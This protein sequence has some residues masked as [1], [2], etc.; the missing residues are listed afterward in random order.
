M[1]QAAEGQT[2]NTRGPAGTLPLN[3]FETETSFNP[4][5][6]QDLRPSD[7]CEYSEEGEDSEEDTPH[8]V[9]KFSTDNDDDD[10]DSEGDVDNEET[11]QKPFTRQKAIAA[12][13]FSDGH[14]G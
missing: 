13:C 2:G 14:L 1:C 7:C 10:S 9:N 3:F 6:F 4:I 8:D 11:V 5:D 12:G